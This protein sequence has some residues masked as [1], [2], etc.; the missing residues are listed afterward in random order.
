[1]S[2][3]PKAP[4]VGAGGFGCAFLRLTLPIVLT[5]LLSSVA[6]AQT[7]GRTLSLSSALERTLGNNPSLNLYVFRREALEGAAFTANLRPAY[8]VEFEAENFGG[9]GETEAFDSAE[10][11]LSLSSVLELGDKRG[12]RSD[13]V[14][15]T[16][17]IVDTQLQLESL[18][19][20][21]EVTRRFI[22]TLAAQA[23]VELSN[24]AVRLAEETLATVQKRASA[25]A[26]S[27]AEVSRAQSSLAMARLML[28]S[29]AQ[30]LESLKLSLAALWGEQTP[31]FDKVSGDLFQ[32][33]NDKSLD[34]LYGT[35]ERNP[36]ITMF[37]DQERLKDSELRLARTQSKS[38]LSW[39]VG[40]RRFRE[41]EDTAL[42]AGLAMPLFSAR[43]NTGEISR[44]RS[45]RS[46]IA[47]QREADI[48]KLRALLF[49]AYNTRQQAKFAVTQ[50]KD[51]VIPSLEEALK[52]TRKG[53]QRGRFSYLDY[54]SVSKELLESKRM[55][56]ESAAAVLT[57]GAEIEQLSADSLSVDRF[58]PNNDT[59]GIR[60]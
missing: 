55:L 10:L 54:I 36:A 35:L 25:G 9:S 15:T 29:E 38:D 34:A 59:P 47:L 42:V 51:S 48:L 53:Y 31:T 50:L 12:A 57:Y 39:S 6:N 20:L 33:G 1:M 23:R 52:Q 30:L 18:E 28:A 21:A 41:T 37:V 45:E 26:I 14:S 44:L 4:W 17:S 2:Y 5:L 49:G 24:D 27:Q 13:L 7:P 43:R 58:I 19:L 3:L 60:K 22:D 8:E 11:T 32:F 40:V 16:R 46:A 56:I